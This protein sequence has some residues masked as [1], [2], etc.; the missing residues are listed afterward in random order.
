MIIILAIS[1]IGLKF[2]TY[3]N[4]STAAAMLDRLNPLVKTEILYTKTTESYEYKFPDA[5]SKIEN[6]A[7]IQSC[8]TKNGKARKVEYISFEKQL[9]P[10]KFLKLITKG[11]SVLEWEEVNEKELPEKVKLLL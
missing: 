2:Y 7:Y 1:I 5:V 10:N 8:Y 4:T 6:F 9:A 11:Q 3:N